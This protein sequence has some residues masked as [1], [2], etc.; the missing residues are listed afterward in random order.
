M[1]FRDLSIRRKLTVLILTSSVLGLVLACVGLAAYERRSFR[2]STTSELSALADTLGANA[3]A[4]LVFNDP[5]TAAEMLGALR[6]EPHILGARLYDANGKVFA[7]YRRTDAGSE[8][9]MPP[10]RAR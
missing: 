1:L 8:F 7:E 5:K 9:S 4:S 3:A 6:T 10:W 2:A